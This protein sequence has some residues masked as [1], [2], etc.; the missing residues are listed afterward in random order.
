MQTPFPLTSAEISAGIRLQDAAI[1]DLFCRELRRR[2]ERAACSADPPF[3]MDELDDCFAT[4]FLQLC[5]LIGSNRY[6][7][8][9][10]IFAYA[11]RVIHN[12]V[13]DH[14]KAE[15]RRRNRL[16][17]VEGRSEPLVHAGQEDL[18]ALPGAD[19]GAFAQAALEV[20]QWGWY[21]HY[22]RTTPSRRLLLD[23]LV[24]GYTPLQIA[25]ELGLSYQNVRTTL[26]FLRRQLRACQA[27]SA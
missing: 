27:R 20:G 7:E 24:L 9:G 12:A 11:R 16:Q 23:L 19:R 3:T 5:E 26:S 1:M 22:C 6:E 10:R 21:R 13:R 14:R 17:E 4:G 18:A 15:Q 8:S 2:L 25:D